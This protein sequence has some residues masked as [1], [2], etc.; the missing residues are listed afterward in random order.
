[1]GNYA[2]ADES[3]A[4]QEDAKPKQFDK[5]GLINSKSVPMSDEEADAATKQAVEK[6]SKQVEMSVPETKA[7]ILKAQRELQTK[8]PKEQVS[9]SN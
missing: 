9:E 5:L 2:V 3:P 4:N 7:A 1:M 6:F 8:A